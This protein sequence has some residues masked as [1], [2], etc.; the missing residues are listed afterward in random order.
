LLPAAPSPSPPRHESLKAD[1]I[2]TL[3]PALPTA[4]STAMSS[5][6]G[7][8]ISYKPQVNRAIT[9][10][11]AEAKQISY[12][13]NDWGDD[14]D[15]YYQPTPSSARGGQQAGWPAPVASGQRY[16]AQPPQQGV[17]PANR[18]FT[19]PS[20]TRSNGRQSF[21]RGDERRNF[22]AHAPS[23]S[24]EGP[25]PTA[26]Q[27]PFPELQPDFQPPYQEPSTRALHG[28][29]P[30]HLQTQARPPSRDRPPALQPA[31]RDQAQYK[32]P[33]SA[34]D[35]RGAPYQ[36]PAGGG[37]Y[38]D[39]GR[40]S[41][42]SG[43]PSASDLQGR[44][45]S[46]YRTMNPPLTARS[47]P[48]RD[49]S[50]AKGFPPRKSSLSQDTP[51]LEPSLQPASSTST[52][53]GTPA[54]DNPKPLPFI[55]PADI[56]K[57]MEEEREK[58][59]EKERRS[60][61]S[62]RPS[63]D[64][65][66][67][68]P[69]DRDIFTSARQSQESS[70]PRIDAGSGTFRDNHSPARVPPSSLHTSEQLPSESK[71][72]DRSED[73]ETT[74]KL[75]PTLDPVAERKSEYGF[76]N[77]LKDAGPTQPPSVQP[78]ASA[79]LG[80]PTPLSASSTRSE[81]AEPL[82]A[83][84]ASSIYSDGPDPV[85]ASSQSSGKS[86]PQF[87][88]VLHGLSDFGTNFLD[89]SST[90]RDNLSAVRRPAV[91]S[92][93][94]QTNASESTRAP[95]RRDQDA[96]TTVAAVPDPI[97]AEMRQTAPVDLR[98]GIH[99]DFNGSQNQVPHA[100]LSTTESIGRSNS[101]SAS[102]ISPIIGG[103]TSPFPTRA[104]VHPRTGL[105][106]SSSEAMDEAAITPP[107]SAAPQ[108][109]MLQEAAQTVAE[110]ELPPPPPPIKDGFRK[111]YSIPSHG[112]SQTR[113]PLSVGTVGVPE[114]ARPPK[115]I[116][117]S[118]DTR[119]AWEVTPS[120][121]GGRPDLDSQ[122]KPVST[123]VELKDS[124]LPAPTSN[125]PL[126]GEPST[127]STV[128]A[129]AEKLESH[130]GRASPV[131]SLNRDPEIPRPLNSRSESFRPAL[132]GGW[133]SYRTN[134]DAA[135]FQQERGASTSGVE[136]AS[137]L[138][139]GNRDG[140]EDSPVSSE[141]DDIPRAGPPKRRREESDYGPSKTAFAAAVAARSAL[142][143][144]FTSS[145]DLDPGRNE[146]AY[147]HEVSEDESMPT[148]WVA[149]ED[150]SRKDLENDVSK[151]QGGTLASHPEEKP[152]APSP[153]APSPPAKDTPSE[154]DTPTSTLGYF[155]APLRTSRTTETIPPIMSDMS[156]SGPPPL[157]PALSSDTTIQDTDNDRLRKEIV[158]S[159][160]PKSTQNEGELART[161]EDN[162]PLP[163]MRVANEP[164]SRSLGTPTPAVVFADSN[165]S[166]TRKLNVNSDQ[167]KLSQS[168]MTMTPRITDKVLP[169]PDTSVDDERQSDTIHVQGVAHREDRP[170]LEQRFSWEP[171][172][173]I[174]P[175]LPTEF[176]ES[177]SLSPP[178]TPQGARGEADSPETIRPYGPPNT[179]CISNSPRVAP[180][181][182]PA[183]TL[184]QVQD[185]GP[186]GHGEVGNVA[187]VLQQGA[188][189]QPSFRPSPTG[190]PAADSTPI[191]HSSAKE[192]PFREILLLG[193]PQ[194]RIQAFN[195]N[196]GLVASQ[197]TGLGEWLKDMGDQLPEHSEILR[198]SGRFSMYENDSP[199]SFR[200]S[201]GRSK[202]RLAS[203]AN[204]SQ[205]TDPEYE[206]SISNSPSG[207]RGSNIHMPGQGKKL[208]KDA[209]KIGGQAGSVAKG[210]FTK[211][212]NKLRAGSGDKVAM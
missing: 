108:Q 158:R 50:P 97:N 116:A 186:R 92:E 129:L 8:P 144:A 4:L 193:T 206:P 25:Y 73:T 52:T 82:T 114:S 79:S 36:D 29:P 120:L 35:A 39:N 7:T 121:S 55:R 68:R 104:G 85:T 117:T 210:L 77:M 150:V 212:K 86:L 72:L 134:A 100:S 76:E 47:Q 32:R 190:L 81:Q 119:Q 96:V 59:R 184:R 169:Q 83:I 106:P 137:G 179:L 49:D 65:N 128:R 48:S 74:R 182:A 78:A 148:H 147:S 181:M 152:R 171:Q 138:T 88:P 102:E 27:N 15:D 30:L 131:V 170:Q 202:F 61:E 208:L 87:L 173:E 71:S 162:T 34:L 199:M 183:D 132:P 91:E 28:P 115:S 164:D 13:G 176:G 33:P 189:M 174:A 194:D 110:P 122:T 23:S 16:H 2:E 142:V 155:P 3:D 107:Q 11:W 94:V 146:T 163:R 160:T 20:P 80:H 22:S 209:G 95:L 63:V 12:E 58:E 105:Y 172:P 46:P 38:G 204:N 154:T 67:S 201:P 192:M 145:A 149:G 161:L 56:Y 118:T 84:S 143:G 127:K 141:D 24:F 166:D 69:R 98:S 10:R 196:R 40:R 203:L 57:R 113:T 42:S 66:A 93:T 159:L 64:S 45:E 19:N 54:S 6:G 44:S 205:S 136:P 103:A 109:S 130:S 133:Q 140:P 89:Q 124:P 53:N 139:S 195:A 188:P 168:Q 21:D 26:Q 185:D 75:K 70:H 175:S 51:I 17:T 62:S 197:D 9:K 37:T 177:A 99:Q 167:V 60:Q 111:D 5:S 165:H 101:A 207:G 90:Q 41:E 151:D 112:E 126:S 43:R 187:E 180:S 135:S 31:S 157:L 14:D 125:S 200:Q 191:L 153:V 1:E 156:P 123:R 198:S 18:S 211:G 178:R